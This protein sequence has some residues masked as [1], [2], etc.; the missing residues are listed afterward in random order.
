MDL[1]INNYDINELCNIFKIEITNIDNEYLKK[2][3]TE[4]IKMIQDND[5]KELEN[6]KINIIKFYTDA[7]FK[8]T[9]FSNENSKLNDINENLKSINENIVNNNILNQ[10]LK[11]NKLE[12]SPHY[13][14]KKPNDYTLNVFNKE[15]RSGIVNP[16]YRQVI[17]KYININ[18][19]F[20]DNYITTQSN[21]FSLNL[22]SPLT[23]VLSMKV[24]DHD[25]PFVVHTISSNYNNN[26]FRIRPE[27]DPSTSIDNSFI[28]IIISNGSY[29]FNC[30]LDEINSKLS[31]N[32]D[33]S[34]VKIKFIK[35]K[36]FWEFYSDNSSNF[37][38]D[39]FFN[40]FPCI[41]NGN[42]NKNNTI[43][44]QLTLGWILGFR[45]SYIE[46]NYKELTK[47][48]EQKVNK[49]EC[50]TVDNGKNIKSN[51]NLLEKYNP[52]DS[53]IG[54]YYK[55]NNKYKG[56]A[57]YDP[58]FNSYFLLSIN[59]FMNNHNTTFISPFKESSNSN[60][61]II[62]RIPATTNNSSNFI[63]PERIYFG[64]TTINKLDIKLYDEY[65]R[66][67]ELNNSDYSF[68]LEA[69][70]LYEN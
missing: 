27:G 67:V 52:S 8:L 33:I 1:D 45:G 50:C 55:G 35:K 31:I 18:T 44:S 65:G 47:N 13:L 17:K 32:S 15:I 16:L 19:R 38:L 42:N 58:H 14:I 37:E 53:K 24:I 5:S 40:N 4:K 43:N 12:Q 51:I 2:S 10:N 23:N 22:P 34:N 30:L 25:M 46:K 68:V 64:P 59:D 69:Q 70:I 6:N 66:L 49:I 57:I 9:E 11:K 54:T 20:R 60:Q 48:L 36:G 39:F 26:R 28:E 63:Y 21:N 56:E 62:A 61:N 29:T 3:L 7:Y 41:N